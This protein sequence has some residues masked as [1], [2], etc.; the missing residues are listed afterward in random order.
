[1]TNATTPK[2]L[3]IEDDPANP[4]HIVTVFAVSARQAT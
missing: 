2:I 4:R 1:M 3:V